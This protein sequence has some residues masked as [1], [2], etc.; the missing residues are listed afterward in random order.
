[1]FENNKREVET[2]G[3]L[4]SCYH[5]EFLDSETL[6]RMSEQVAE[7]KNAL[8]AVAENMD[9]YWEKTELQCRDPTAA[10]GA[11]KLNSRSIHFDFEKASRSE[12]TEYSK[13]IT[14]DLMLRGLSPL[15]SLST[16]QNW[17][18]KPCWWMRALRLTK[19]NW[20]G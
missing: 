7:Y 3:K 6:E 14:R 13:M 4:W 11:D 20:K 18:K 8:G 9:D 16:R 1:V 15:G 2:S 5:W 10:Q 17:L 12:R 19:E